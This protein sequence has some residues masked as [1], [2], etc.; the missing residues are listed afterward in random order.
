MNDTASSVI[1]DAELLQRMVQTHDARFDARYWDVFKTLVAPRLP[2][3]AT[4][5]DL[6]CGPGLY[7]HNLT[8]RLPNALF[9]GYDKAA[10]MTAAARQLLGH[11]S[12]VAIHDHDFDQ[13]MPAVPEGSVDL[14][15][16]NFFF[17]YFDYPLPLL[18]FV[19]RSLHPTHG[20]LQVFDWVRTPLKDYLGNVR[21]DDAEGLRRRFH[22]F[23]NHNRYTFEDLHWLLVEN[24]FQVVFA[25]R[26]RTSHALLL[27]TPRLTGKL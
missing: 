23:P 1:S 6:G 20:V 8:D 27:A 25:E 5:V 3:E 17:H 16:M 24:G 22:L 15:A 19:R 11:H 26:V 7:L 18:D 10:D 21:P 4:V 12:A 2:Q 9:A 13:G 14:M